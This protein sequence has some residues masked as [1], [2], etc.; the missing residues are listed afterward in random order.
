MNQQRI[1]IIWRVLLSAAVG[2]T[3]SFALAKTF[4]DFD[5]RAFI[6]QLFLVLIPAAA[7][8][9][10]L[11][12]LLPFLERSLAGAAA[13][14]RAIIF[15]W[16]FIPA[17]L[18]GVVVQF[19]FPV[20]VLLF[21]LS[22]LIIVPAVPAVQI[23]LETGGRLRVIGAWAF[24]FFFS[25]FLLGFL[26]NFYTSP[27]EVILLTILFQVLL[28]VVGYFLMGRVRRVAGERWFDA[29]V[30][31]VLFVLVIAFVLWLFQANRQVSLFSFTYFVLDIK[32]SGI[33]LF[34][35]LLA[36]PWQA[37]LHLKLK[38]SG[39]YNWLKQTKV[40]AY[41]SA[42]LAG[43]S[44][45]FVFFV[46]YLLFA[47]VIN[48]PRF[49]VDD[50]FFDADGMNY[51]N[52]LVTNNWQDYYWR[53]VHPFMILLFRPLVS[54]IAFFLKGD[55]L[56]GA[57]VFVALGGAACVY[58]AWTF[59]KSASGSSVYASLIAALLGLSASHLIFGSLIESYI[60]LAASLLLFQVLLIKDKP[61]PPL[62]AAGVVTIG[63]T[64]TNFAQNV[65]ALFAV[66]PNIRQ[67]IR[68]VT[69]VVVL[70]VLFTL[71]NNLLFPNSHPFFFVPSTLQ[72]EQQ[73]LFPLN[74][75]RAQALTRIFFFHNVVAP[76][77]IFYD[78]DIPFIQFRFFKPEINELSRYEQP[79]QVAASWFWLGLMA[80]AGMLFLLNIKKNPHLR[81]SIAL[82]GCMA[83]NMGLHLR[84]G[85]ELFL[86][87]P[88]WTYALIL[89]LGLAWQ[90]VHDRKWF[91]ALLLA[92]LFLLVWNNGVLLMTILEVLAEQV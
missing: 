59:I 38:F 47:S 18:S 36:L 24:A 76:E 37:W 19:S 62:I 63:I 3:A 20:F 8:L 87:S 56:W 43:I 46:L 66:R 29:L 32:T 49:D 73:N 79:V 42:N 51:R 48:D 22:I 64:Y 50:I 15:I 25:N 75:L 72:A 1:G 91:Q 12:Y 80:L 89:L 7:L 55:R 54:L 26:D 69:S 23:L 61:L 13:P 67:M 39:L 21:F 14:A 86:Y 4:F 77:P 9:I 33:F 5:T 81:L 31:G 40:Y 34:V 68:Y 70:W 35:S 27:G 60:F 52:R 17:L 41:M 85:K 88:N 11:L 10:C 53:S 83:L 44:L 74:T 65:I 30:H 90:Q 92:F 57:Y 71:A 16:A 28:S 45:A 78:E 82:M 2:M 58:L 6:D 84:Y